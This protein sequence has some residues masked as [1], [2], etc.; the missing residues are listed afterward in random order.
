MTHFYPKVVVTNNPGFSFT[1]AKTHV[2]VNLC[3]MCMILNI[4]SNLSMKPYAFCFFEIAMILSIFQSYS[5]LKAKMSCF[6]LVS[7]Q[8]D[9]NFYPVGKVNICA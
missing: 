9:F 4:F 3:Y 6:S 5:A 1:A 2:F 7:N 8:L